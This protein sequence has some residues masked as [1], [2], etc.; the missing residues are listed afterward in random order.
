MIYFSSSYRTINY[1]NARA[2]SLAHNPRQCRESSSHG[3][4]SGPHNCGTTE[5]QLRHNC[6][7]KAATIKEFGRKNTTYEKKKK[8]N[9]QT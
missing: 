4:W 3:V 7:E 2:R 6:V 1:T 5:T 8:N 9:V